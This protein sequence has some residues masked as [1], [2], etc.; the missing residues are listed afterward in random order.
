MA[1]IKLPRLPSNWK[2]QPQL[3]ERYWDDVLKTLEKTFNGLLALPI[4]EQAVQ[5]AKNFSQEAKDAASLVAELSSTQAEE[6][7]KVSSYP[8]SSSGNILEADSTGLVTIQSHTRK[9]GD[10][11]LH[12]D[13]VINGGSIST[14]AAPNDR[15]RVYYKDDNLTGGSVSFLFTKDPD[16]PVPQGKGFYSVGA[17]LIPAAGLVDGDALGPPGF[18]YF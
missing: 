5:D 8:Y 18:V 3:F 4:I 11:A 10:S 15:I 9:F 7:S 6:A 17:V 14:S 16:S 12:P 1:D 2:D 13:L